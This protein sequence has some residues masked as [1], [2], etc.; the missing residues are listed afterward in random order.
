[1]TP[2]HSLQT[3]AVLDYAREKYH[4]EPEFLWATPQNSKTS[5]LRH[6]DNRKWFAAFVVVKESKIRPV[7]EGANHNGTTSDIDPRI[8]SMTTDITAPDDRYIEILDLRFDKGEAR[9]FVSSAAGVY[10]GYHMNKD[11][12]I[13]IVLDN[14]L[15]TPTILALLD[16]SHA[17]TAG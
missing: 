12:W 2:Y 5:I 17:L 9:A 10:P 14:S 3:Q 11:N 7:G 15:P 4:A 16:R 13:T 6:A 8:A 1:M